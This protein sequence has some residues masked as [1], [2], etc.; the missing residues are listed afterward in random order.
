MRNPAVLVAETRLFH[1]AEPEG[2]VFPAGETW[3]GDAWFDKP[4]GRDVGA[5]TTKQ[6]MKDLI[7]AQ[8]TVDRLG[9]LLAS[10]DHDLA[11]LA[12]E[13]DAAKGALAALEQRA[14]TAETALAASEG[15]ARNYMQERDAA[16]ADA[17]RFSDQIAAA[18]TKKTEAA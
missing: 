5:D 13:R 15:A 8:D 2:R 12:G 4:G 10:K 3:P 14:I 11:V 16:R 1:P 17:K 6:A 7:A 9:G 18:K